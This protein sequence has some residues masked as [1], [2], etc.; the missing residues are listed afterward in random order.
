MVAQSQTPQRK[1]RVYN[2]GERSYLEMYLFATE[3]VSRA[4]R[5]MAI[6]AC[7]LLHVER[8]SLSCCVFSFASCAVARS[9]WR[10]IRAS[11]LNL[12]FFNGFRLVF[13]GTQRQSHLTP[14][15]HTP[16][17]TPLATPNIFYNQGMETTSGSMLLPTRVLLQMEGGDDSIECSVHT[18][19][20]PLQREFRHVF[21]DAYLVDTGVQA[22]IYQTPLPCEIL[23]IPTN[24]KAREDLVAVGEHIEREKDRLLHV[25][26]LISVLFCASVF[27]HLFSI[28]SLFYS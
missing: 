13:G 25:V 28:G 2:F 21:G 19:P 27:K 9:A 11:P 26:R 20:K 23:A 6:A 14:H 16:H 1:R 7:L 10:K 22:S 8:F 18:L 5:V 17:T 15:H 4:N 3:Y 24:Q 12:P